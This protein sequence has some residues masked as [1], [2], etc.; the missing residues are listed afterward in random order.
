MPL[1]DNDFLKIAKARA[2][3]TNEWSWGAWLVNTSGEQIADLK[4]RAVVDRLAF[5]ERFREQGNL[6]LGLNPPLY[7]LAVNRFYYSMYHAMRAVA[8]HYYGGDD[9]ESH[10]SL[11]TKVPPGFTNASNWQNFLKNAR[12]HRNSAD[13][14]PYP[15]ADVTW[16]QVSQELRDQCDEL[17]LLC[18]QYLKA[19]GCKFL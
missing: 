1:T 18:M 3:V 19:N 4:C 11:P 8:Y 13:Y 15:A 2:G 5:A 10:S 16:R 7:R 6:S 14:D 17:R 12:E 9:H